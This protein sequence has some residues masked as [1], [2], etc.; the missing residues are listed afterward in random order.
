MNVVVAILGRAAVDAPYAELTTS[1]VVVSDAPVPCTPAVPPAAAGQ[2]LALRITSDDTVMVQLGQWLDPANRPA[3]VPIE[4]GQGNVIGT[5]P[6]PEP[7]VRGEYVA[8]D[9][10][11]RQVPFNVGNSI[12]LRRPGVAAE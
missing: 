4:D 1:T 12:A 8:W 5:E 6:G 2:E 11:S 3:P 9:R 7:Y 10:A